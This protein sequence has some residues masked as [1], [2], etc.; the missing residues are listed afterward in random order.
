MYG[1]D[2]SQFPVPSDRTPNDPAVLLTHKTVLAV[3]NRQHC[4]EKDDK[5]ERVNPKVKKFMIG[6]AKN[7][8][9]S[10]VKFMGGQCLLIAKVRLG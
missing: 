5:V 6:H 3:Y 1:R 9:W 2:D 10:H 7:L 4:N 8:K